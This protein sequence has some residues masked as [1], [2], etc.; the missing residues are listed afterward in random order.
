MFDDDDG[1]FSVDNFSIEFSM[2]ITIFNSTEFS[3]QI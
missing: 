1:I 3:Q 2:L